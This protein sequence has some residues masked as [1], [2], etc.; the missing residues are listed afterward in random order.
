MKDVSRDMEN[1]IPTTF[2][3]D[4]KTNIR[5]SALGGVLGY[6]E[7]VSAFKEALTGVDV[8]LDDIKVGKFVKKT[9][10]DAIYT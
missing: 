9:V 4:T 1:A 8:E 6:T 5:G 7:L 2:D 3:I 10:T